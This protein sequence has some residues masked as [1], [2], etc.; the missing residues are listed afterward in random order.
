MKRYFI[1]KLTNKVTG[2]IY[3]GK[4]SSKNPKHRWQRGWG[5][6][7]KNGEGIGNIGRAIVQYGW[8]NF[9]PEVLETD[10]SKEEAIEKERYYIASYRATEPGVGYNIREEKYNHTTL[11]NEYQSEYQRTRYNNDGEYKQRRKE[12]FKKWEEKFKA[13]HGCTFT[14]WKKRQSKIAQND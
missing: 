14:T 12:Y 1:Y 5:Y 3:I 10:L 6:R 13:E 9:I 8:D 4:S 2:E 7:K 11:Y